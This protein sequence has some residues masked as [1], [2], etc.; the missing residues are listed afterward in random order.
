MSR[1]RSNGTGPRELKVCDTLSLHSLLPSSHSLVQALPANRRGS[2]DWQMTWF[3][4]MG[5]DIRRNQDIKFSFFRSIDEDYTPENLVFTDTLYE[6]ADQYVQLPSPDFA[7]P[8]PLININFPVQARTETPEQREQNWSQLQGDG[9]LELCVE[10]PIQEES[11]QG[12]KTIVSHA[13]ISLPPSSLSHSFFL[14]SVL[15]VSALLDSFAHRPQLRCHLRSRGLAQVCAD[16]LLARGGRYIDG[17]CASE[18]QLMCQVLGCNTA[19]E[20]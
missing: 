3:I 6:C 12:G 14:D 8:D 19:I 17:E 15:F 2:R 5:D 16:D 9:R 13:L 4:N 7:F 18:V 1:A 11:R 10:R 20:R